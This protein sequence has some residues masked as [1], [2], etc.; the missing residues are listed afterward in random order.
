MTLSETPDDTTADSTTYYRI[1]RTHM[2]ILLCDD[3][4]PSAPALTL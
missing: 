2:Q 1:L 4:K 3:R